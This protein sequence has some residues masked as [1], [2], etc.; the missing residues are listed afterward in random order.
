MGM[1]KAK[2][3]AKR[4]DVKIVK[5]LVWFKFVQVLEVL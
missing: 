4:S 2:K 5:E 3:L 1:I